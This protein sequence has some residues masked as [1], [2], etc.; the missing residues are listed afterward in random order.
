MKRLRPDEID[1]LKHPERF[2]FDYFREKTLDP[3][4]EAAALGIADEELLNYYDNRYHKEAGSS[5][6]ST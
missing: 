2:T 6:G 1:Y 4:P 3:L 5:S